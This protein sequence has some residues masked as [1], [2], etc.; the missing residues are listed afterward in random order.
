MLTILRKRNPTIPFYSVLD[1][2]FAPYGQL[3]TDF[4]AT[5]FI[6]AA[7]SIP[8]PQSGAACNPSQPEFEALPAAEDIRKEFFG[9]LPTQIG[10]CYGHSNQLNALEWHC[11]NELNI[12]V[13]DFV[14]LLAQ[15]S[16]LKDNKLCSDQVKAFYVPAGSVLEIYSQTLHFCPCEVNAAGFGCIVALSAGTNIPLTEHVANKL[17]FKQNK[18]LIAHNDNLALIEKGILP[19]ISGDNLQVLY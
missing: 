5:T 3:V 4:D 6:A 9:T 11:C 17:Q 14:L 18:W 8:L 2:E 16:D 13:T 10:Y 15:R 12:A 7:K 1:P 19:G